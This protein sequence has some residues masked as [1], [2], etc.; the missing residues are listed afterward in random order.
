MAPL[1][2]GADNNPIYTTLTSSARGCHRALKRPRL[3]KF[4][5]PLRVKLGCSVASALSP[6]HAEEQTIVLKFG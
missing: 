2:A 1:R 3:R 4:V 6:L 5:G